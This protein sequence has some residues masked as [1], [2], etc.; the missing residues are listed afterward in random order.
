MKAKKILKCDNCETIMTKA[1]NA[2]I[3]DNNIFCCQDCLCNY[4]GE[5]IDIEDDDK[6]FGYDRKQ[7]L[8]DYGVITRAKK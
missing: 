6:S 2:W 5:Y 3:T 4:M 7:L 8:N 1:D